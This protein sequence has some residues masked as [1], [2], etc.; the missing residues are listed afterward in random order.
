[1]NKIID[2]LFRHYLQDLYIR[3][4]EI[5]NVLQ[6]ARMDEAAIQ[7]QTFD[8][9][10]NRLKSTL[11]NEKFLSEESLKSEIIRLNTFMTNSVKKVKRAD[12]PY[13]QSVKALKRNR[14]M[15]GDVTEKLKE[16]MG[17]LGVLFGAIEDIER[18]INDEIQ[19]IEYK[20]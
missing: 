13:Y 19:Q 10:M 14:Q 7:L 20:G 9:E 1:M 5:Q 4:S 8:A 12:E 6:K 16:L 3:K 11:E 17:L 2:W 15:T 18:N